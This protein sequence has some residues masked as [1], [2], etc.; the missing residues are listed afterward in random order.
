MMHVEWIDPNGLKK[1][2]C[3]LDSFTP[4]NCKEK[5]RIIFLKKYTSLIDK[6]YSAETTGP[7][8]LPGR[9]AC[10]N[11]TQTREGRL[12]CRSMEGPIWEDNTYSYICVQGM[13]SALRPFLIRQWVHD[14]DIENCHASI[15]FQLGSYFHLWPENVSKNMQPLNLS[16]LEK[17]C[18]DRNSF[19]NNICNTH[20]L[21]TDEE[22]YKGYRKGLCK[23]LLL[24]ILYGG[25]YE[26]WLHENKLG[27]FVKSKD[28]QKLEREIVFLREAL[29]NSKRFKHIFDLEINVQR[30]R[31]RDDESIK[32]GIFSKIAQHLE[33][34]ILKAMRIFL[35]NEG[36]TIH[37]LIFDGL[38][39]EHRN[40]MSLNLKEMEK[41]VEFETQFKVVITEK[42]LYMVE[43]NIQKL[44]NGN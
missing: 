16:M 41:Y 22:M 30:K 29:I 18:N 13:P 24:R 27:I 7:N 26:S 31:K 10:F 3:I 12:Y 42:E 5:E 1:I 28:V 8:N 40:N 37:S 20:C 32:R 43:P 9:Y 44:I 39:V 11:Y 35:M 25:K 2:Q 6:I 21:P 33:C 15:L 34:K 17:V 36:W 4:T 38:T 23:P 14:I 19:I